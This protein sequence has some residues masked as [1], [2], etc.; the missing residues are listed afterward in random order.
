MKT[1][2]TSSYGAKPIMTI[3]NDIVNYNKQGSINLQPDYQRGFVWDA[4]LQVRLIYSLIRNFPIGNVVFRVKNGINEVV[5]GQQRLTTVH[6]FVNDDLA[7]KGNDARQIIRF[8]VDHIENKLGDDP[9]FEQLQKKL[10]NK[11]S[12]KLSFSN[13]PKNLQM[14]IWSYNINITFL[15]D[16]SDSEV[17]EYFMFVQNQERLRAGEL[18]NSFPATILDDYLNAIDDLKL[19]L[20]KINFKS[21]KHLEFNKQFYS[22]IGLITNNINYGVNDKR[23]MDFA[24]NVPKDLDN[25]KLISNMINGINVITNDNKIKDKSIEFAN[26]RSTKFLLLLLAF[27]FIDLEKDVNKQLNNLSIIN[28]KIA[29][30]NSSKPDA[31]KNEFEDYSDKVIEDFSDIASLS[32]GS[33]SFREVRSYMSRLGYYIKAFNGSKTKQSKF[34]VE[35]MPLNKVKGQSYN[36]TKI[37]VKDA[38][39][40]QNRK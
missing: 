26:V 39:K 34:D 36:P 23:I 5:D 2:M 6:N 31:I 30:F 15:N 9:K 16:A 25:T 20:N 13:L 32:T 3:N 24:L 27:G 37:M 40:K 21:N 35:Y 10:S 22:I 28:K 38:M 19:F 8:I 17:K 29:A 12:I 4:K 14:Q 33:H 18:I 7:I 1:F 11:T